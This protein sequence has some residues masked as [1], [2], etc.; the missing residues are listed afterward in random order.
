MLLSNQQRFLL[1]AL[2]TLGGA[3]LGQLTGLLQPV[4]CPGKPEHAP[5]IVKAAISQ[6]RYCNVKLCQEGD[7]FFWPGRRPS[8]LQ[9]EAVDVMLELAGTG[10]LS[11]RCGKPPILLRFSIQEQKVRLFTVTT[12]G[13]DLYGIELHHTERIILLFDGEGKPHALPVSNKQFFAVR[14][15]DGTH[16]FFSVSAQSDGR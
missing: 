12:P 5:Q 6:M 9:M 8:Q 7:L 3:N 1:D 2:D 15:S 11:Y 16:R 13:T 14:Q 10:M 4:F